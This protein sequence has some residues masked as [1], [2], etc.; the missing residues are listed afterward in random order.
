M[1]TNKY[2]GLKRR[3][4]RKTKHKSRALF[5]LKK[6]LEGNREINFEFWGWDTDESS[7]Y[8]GIQIYFD[9]PIIPSNFI[10]SVEEAL[11]EIFNG[12]FQEKRIPEGSPQAEISLASKNT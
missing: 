2:R 10:K 9:T 1:N 5:D 4:E 3:Q 11:I 8:L 12:Y 7:P 6:M